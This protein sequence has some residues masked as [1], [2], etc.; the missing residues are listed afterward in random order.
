MCIF[1]ALIDPPPPLP[2]YPTLSPGASVSASSTV[3]A[4]AVAA[5]TSVNQDGVSDLSEDDDDPAM[6]DA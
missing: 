5:S 2:F 3:R 4:S 1:H 6:L